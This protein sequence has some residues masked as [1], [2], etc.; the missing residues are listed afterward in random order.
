MPPKRKAS[1]PP[2]GSLSVRALKGAKSPQSLST[3][4]SSSSL[5]DGDDKD[6][7]AGLRDRANSSGDTGDFLSYLLLNSDS[8]PDSVFASQVREYKDRNDDTS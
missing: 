4:T 1:S 8:I 7:F 5:P 6:T 3:A 2:V